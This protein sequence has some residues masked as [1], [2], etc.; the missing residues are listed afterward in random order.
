MHIGV[1]IPNTGTV[2]TNTMW[3][4]ISLIYRTR[5]N[6]HLI[7]REGCYVQ[8]NRWQ[9]VKQAMLEGCDK[10]L[11]V[12]A[13]MQFDGDALNRLLAHNKPIVGAN[14]YTRTFPL[15][16]TV[17]VPGTTGPTG[18]TGST[19]VIPHELFECF[20]VGTGL[21][22]VDMAVFRALPQPWFA[23]THLPDGSL[24]YGEDVW[25]CRQARKHGFSVWCDPTFDVSHIGDFRYKDYER[26]EEPGGGVD[27]PGEQ[28]AVAD[29]S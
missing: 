2:K 6:L 13:D 4:I 24:E 27:T 22:L 25:F 10:L 20:A 16:S 3:S 29:K 18:E 21:M 8:L 19:A 26:F 14:Y 17:K 5:H 7:G 15:V 1:G 12:D 23:V 28:M 11:F 9:I